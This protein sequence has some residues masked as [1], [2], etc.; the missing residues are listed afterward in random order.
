ML[1]HKIP[2]SN[3]GCALRDIKCHPKSS[4]SEDNK[5]RMSSVAMENC[6]FIV[7]L[8]IKVIKYYNFPEF[9]VCLPEGIL[10]RNFGP[11]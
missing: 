11:L 5:K 3:D 2:I 4:V 6:T 8:P 9:F 7:D 10:S 1:G